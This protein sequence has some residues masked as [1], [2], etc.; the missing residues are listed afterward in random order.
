M[1]RGRG[2]VPDGLELYLQAFQAC[3]WWS[4][5]NKDSYLW[6]VVCFLV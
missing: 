4:P 3:A 5:C 2:L 6:Y 1:Y